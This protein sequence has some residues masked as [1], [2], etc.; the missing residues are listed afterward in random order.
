ME[1]QTIIGFINKNWVSIASFSKIFLNSPNKMQRTL[2]KKGK[3]Q[4]PVKTKT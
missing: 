4:V 2:P 3:N 1:F